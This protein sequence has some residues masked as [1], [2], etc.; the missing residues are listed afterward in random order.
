MWGKTSARPGPGSYGSVTT[1]AACG[2]Q[3]LSHLQTLRHVPF[4]ALTRSREGSNVLPSYS[5]GPSTYSPRDFSFGRS[6]TRKDAPVC[7]MGTSKREH[8]ELQYGV[9][10][11]PR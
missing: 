5:R 3:T 11:R 1:R 8:A 2:A 4:G 10:F 7:L 9:V 6:S